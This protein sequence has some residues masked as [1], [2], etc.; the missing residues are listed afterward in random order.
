MIPDIPKRRDAAIA[1]DRQFSFSRRYRVDVPLI[2]NIMIPV[3]DHNGTGQLIRSVR[4]VDFKP[5]HYSALPQQVGIDATRAQLSEEILKD[6][7]IIGLFCNIAARIAA[8][9]QQDALQTVM[10]HN[11]G[12]HIEGNGITIDSAGNL[13]GT[14]WDAHNSSKTA[15]YALVDDTYSPIPGVFVPNCIKIGGS[16]DE[17]IDTSY[18]WDVDP[19]LEESVQMR[20]IGVGTELVVVADAP[21]LMRYSRLLNQNFPNTAKHLAKTAGRIFNYLEANGL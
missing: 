17:P 7:P 5:G 4:R 14:E 19:Q 3:G 21:Y 15:A 16:Q 2:E 18:P 9:V 13:L 1:H 20:T 6:F 8:K 11:G 12:N 10:S